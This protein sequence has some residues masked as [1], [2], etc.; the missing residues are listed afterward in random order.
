MNTS[1][2]TNI[3]A[4]L[5]IAVFGTA[6][7]SPI[8]YSLDSNNI[9]AGIIKYQSLST[10]SWDDY[11]I[12]NVNK[13]DPKINSLHEFSQNLLKNTSDIDPEI[14]EILNENFWDLI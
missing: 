10:N 7:I 11:Q 12:F 4:K 8:H 13:I 2:S 3:G 5:I 1:T 6:V 14:L 9:P